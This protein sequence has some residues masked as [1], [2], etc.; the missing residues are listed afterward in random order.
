MKP[1]TWLGHV[2]VVKAR[3]KHRTW[4]DA[5]VIALAVH[6]FSSDDVDKKQLGAIVQVLNEAEPRKPP[7]EAYAG[8][9]RSERQTLA[10]LFRWVENGALASVSR[11]TWTTGSDSLVLQFGDPES[12]VGHV[13]SLMK[14]DPRATWPELGRRWRACTRLSSWSLPTGFPKYAKT[15][16]ALT[17]WRRRQRAQTRLMTPLPERTDL[18]KRYWGLEPGHVLTHPDPEVPDLVVAA[19]RLNL[20]TYPT[21]TFK[22]E[23]CPP[24]RA[25]QE[26]P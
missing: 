16:A 15:K 3:S 5:D 25:P 2:A 7:G 26:P 17:A 12:L 19:V 18:M 22:E 23:P 20:D 14:A 10:A 24:P 11:P 6:L 8:G 1:V 4:S 9:V 21:V 13:F